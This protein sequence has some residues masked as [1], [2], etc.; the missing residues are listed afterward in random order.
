MLKRGGSSVDA[1]IATALCQGVINFEHH[2]IGGGCVMTIYERF[3]CCFSGWFGIYL[4]F[5]TIQL[6]SC[7]RVR[8]ILCEFEA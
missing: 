8:C 4:L 3:V 5:K 1:A 7:T 2:G 6:S